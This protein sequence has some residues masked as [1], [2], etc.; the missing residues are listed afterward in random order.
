[1]ASPTREVAWLCPGGQGASNS[2]AHVQAAS[3]SGIVAPGSEASTHQQACQHC[4]GSQ[5]WTCKEK[6]LLSEMSRRSMPCRMY[7][8][9]PYW[10]LTQVSRAYWGSF[11]SYLETWSSQ[12]GDPVLLLPALSGPLSQPGLG[13]SGTPGSACRCTGLAPHTA[14]AA[15]T[16]AVG[17]EAVEHVS[18]PASAQR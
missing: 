16:G 3:S 12:S 2:F 6:E 18:I 1:M 8:C 11:C 13:C 10:V 15:A 5:Q 4:L 7:L 9:C 17:N 14:A